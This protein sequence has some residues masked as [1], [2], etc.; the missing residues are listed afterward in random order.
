[1]N[2][3]ILKHKIKKYIKKNNLNT[4]F[5][6][7]ELV[8]QLLKHKYIN[9]KMHGGNNNINFNFDTY[10][11][12]K[13]HG[14]LLPDTFVT[15]PKGMTLILPA[16][17]GKSNSEN[18]RSIKAKEDEIFDMKGTQIN[19]SNYII[20]NNKKHFIYSEKESICNL[21]LGID[22]IM[23]F[24]SNFIDEKK[25]KTDPSHYEL[26][27]DYCFEN[28]KNLKTEFIKKNN[29]KK[30]NKQKYMFKLLKLSL[31]DGNILKLESQFPSYDDTQYK[32]LSKQMYENIYNNKNYLLS[33]LIYI[34]HN[35]KFNNKENE[36]LIHSFLETHYNELMQ[37]AENA[38]LFFLYASIELCIYALYFCLYDNDIETIKTKLKELTLDAIN[39]LTYFNIILPYF[40]YKNK[41]DRINNF[42]Y[43]TDKFKLISDYINANILNMITRCTPLNS[44]DEEVKIHAQNIVKFN[45]NNICFVLYFLTYYIGKNNT[46]TTNIL[47]DI[48]ENKKNFTLGD[49]IEKINKHN[50]DEQKVILVN[51]CQAYDENNDT[52]CLLKKCIELN[53]KKINK[54]TDTI[55]T[56]MKPAEL[57][58]NIYLNSITIQILVLEFN[59]HLNKNKNYLKTKSYVP[60][61]DDFFSKADK[62]KIIDNNK[63]IDEFYNFCDTLFRYIEIQYLINQHDSDENKNYI[64]IYS[65][66]II[67]TIYDIFFN[68][69][70]IHE[71]TTYSQG[72]PDVSYS[73]DINDFVNFSINYYKNEETKELYF[74]E[75]NIIISEINKFIKL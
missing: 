67:Q 38:N 52:V 32:I 57:L 18:D 64:F 22:T 54:I 71:K 7:S 30:I 19:I 56:I 47:F 75:S 45:I 3:N 41:N 66:Q 15:I 37:K 14:Y 24:L 11:H 53:T 25:N 29:K 48:I 27:F 60:F 73:D 34:L 12:V 16:C 36:E 42:E 21:T 46:I 49:I 31:N 39:K 74:N 44:S 17:C 2:S 40:Y 26:S 13:M 61:F 65:L 1:M 6:N 69:N 62:K 9:N 20:L 28:F 10:Y 5:E 4:T 68:I 55:L 72:I 33:M 59:D 58:V 35:F 23:L 50:P 70:L 43:D 51:S 8:Y 63:Y